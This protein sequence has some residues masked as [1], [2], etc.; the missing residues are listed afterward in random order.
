M[1]TDDHLI[2]PDWNAPAHV[3]AAITTRKGGVSEA[4]YDSLNLGDHVEDLEKNVIMNR[5]LIK[6]QLGFVNEP[7]WLKQ[8][9]GVAVADAGDEASTREADASISQQ[10]QSVCVVMTADC[11]P[12]LFCDQA[13]T[14]VAAAHAGWRGLQAGVLEKTIKS[15]QVEP[16]SILAWLGPAIGEKAFE[17]GEEVRQAFCNDMPEA[18]CAFVP[19]RNE[20]K[21]FANI[22]ELARLRLQ[23]TGLE[24]QNITGGDFC[25]YTDS[26]TFFSYRRDKVTGRMASF[27]WME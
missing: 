4:P 25:T 15:M 5:S 17:V 12:V 3:K 18:E 24:R 19:S 1:M 27:I 20:G 23:K 14:V 13:G 7:F 11:L 21:W 9:H 10:K 8:V 22:Y 16:A 26:D 6:N 2:L